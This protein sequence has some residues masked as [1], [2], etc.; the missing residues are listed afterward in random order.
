MKKLLPF[1]VALFPAVASAQAFRVGSGIQIVPRATAPTKASANGSVWLKLSDSTLHYVNP[2]GTDIALGSG[3]GGGGTTIG[4]TQ[5]AYGTATN[6]L[7][8]VAGFT[9]DSSGGRLSLSGTS[10]N[11]GF[12]TGGTSGLVLQDSTGS[13]GVLSLTS[14]SA[15]LQY[16][17]SPASTLT[18]GSAG[19][20]LSGQP[21][22]LATTSGTPP[23]AGSIRYNGTNTQYSDNGSTWT[24]FAA[25]SVSFPLV[26]SSAMGT[27]TTFTSHLTMENTT[28]A[29]SG[30]T[31]QDSPALALQGRAW[32]SGASIEDGWAIKNDVL[33][34]GGVY[35]SLGFYRNSS[36]GTYGEVLRINGVPSQ[37]CMTG[38]TGY[39]SGGICFNPGVLWLFNSLTD[40]TGTTPQ[41]I[42]SGTALYPYSTG[43]MNIGTSTNLVGTAW[44]NRYAG[45]EQTIAAAST[46]TLD[47]ASGESM[48]LTLGATAVG[49]AGIA[50]G[51]G[52]P[53][54]VIRVEI[55]QDA[56][57]SRVL[58]QA[59]FSTSW[60][61]AGGAY[62]VTATANK[63]DVLTF[64]WD[65]VASK[66]YEVSRATNL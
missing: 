25:G 30:S 62:T 51:T 48:R 65:A 3:G 6:T 20:I 35:S 18:M 10:N 7:G 22:Q 15:V 57:G 1:L 44:A 42:M 66:F 64:V 4:A 23:A 21:L 2:A 59:A 49:A 5:V 36:G 40:I 13:N 24:S 12:L 41:F 19:V 32:V 39:S 26:D 8:G 58:T 16:Q 63:R 56:T 31:K 55:I 61:F 52:Y 27:A 29:T 28:A 14:T 38:G 43:G 11:T 46:L 45:K 33:N 9:W 60:V 17:N 37:G 50:A 34:A 53:G 54:E 47:P